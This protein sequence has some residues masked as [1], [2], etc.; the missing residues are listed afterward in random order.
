MNIDRKRSRFLLWIFLLLIV[1]ACDAETSV[2]NPHGEGAEHIANLLIFM[3]IV[4]AVVYLQVIILFLIALFRR[5]A[6]TTNDT[7]DTKPPSRN[8]QLFI[9]ANGIALPIIILTIVFGFNLVTLAELSP[10][11]ASA[12]LTIEVIGHRWWWEVRYPDHSVVTANEIYIPTGAQVEL[13]LTSADV[14]HSLWVPALNG[15]ADLI[16]GRSN[17]MYLYTDEAGDYLGMCAELCG[18]QHAK[19]QFRVIAQP[20]EDFEQWLEQQRQPAPSPQDE[21]TLRGQQ[22][23]LGSACVYCHTVRGTNASGVI[24]P[25]LTHI[26]SRDTIGAGAVPNTLGN[27]AG[28]IIDPQSIKPGNLMPPMYIEGDDLQA[29]LAYLE[30]LR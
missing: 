23:F 25:D 8:A 1:T 6:A 16:P 21:V 19:M 30:T 11:N 14:I 13:R 24:G 22:I 7:P 20:P 5:R 18:I 10:A 27:L 17:R 29:L 4:G 9:I 15:K 12:D 28:W 2:L 26:A 3:L